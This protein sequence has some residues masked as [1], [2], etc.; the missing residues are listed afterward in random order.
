M[1]SRS[2]T[3]TPPPGATPCTLNTCALMGAW[4]GTTCALNDGLSWHQG[5]RHAPGLRRQARR[6]HRPRHRR[7]LCVI[8]GCLGSPASPPVGA[9]GPLPPVISGG[10][11]DRGEITMAPSGDYPRLNDL[12]LGD[13]VRHES[14][15]A[16]RVLRGASL[17]ALSYGDRLYSTSLLKGALMALIVPAELRGAA[18]R[19]G[20]E[21]DA[22]HGAEAGGAGC[23]WRP[24]WP[25]CGAS[26]GIDNLFFCLSEI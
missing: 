18:R 2:T 5:P 20:A 17:M 22:D 16:P 23:R 24:R 19:G 4:R 6:H 10:V 14:E 9:H 26:P 7:R 15:G 12:R 21:P 8:R 13:Q 25:S 11:V 3:A 1:S